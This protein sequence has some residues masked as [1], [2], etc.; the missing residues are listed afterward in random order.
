MMAAFIVS[1]RGT[2][3]QALLL[4]LSATVSHT[5]VIWLLVFGG[6]HYAAKLDVEKSEPYFQLAS[7]VNILILAAWTFAR[8]RRER[9][10]AAEHAHAHHH[11]HD[12]TLPHSHDD[13]DHDHEHEV[14]ETPEYQDAHAR[15]HAADLQ[16]RFAG[17]TVTAPQIVLFGLTGGLLPCPA[18]FSVL[19]VCLQLKRYTLWLRGRA[20][21]QRRLGNH[22]RQCWGGRGDFAATSGQTLQGL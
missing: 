12:H 8:T 4:G 21:V 1:I 18:A 19:L 15:A 3:G 10:E 16:R 11:H 22:A 13:S 14:T 9:H 7:G 20:G 5:A 6:L 2:L 17:R